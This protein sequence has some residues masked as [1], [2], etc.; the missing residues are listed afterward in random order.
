MLLHRERYS[1]RI[2][3][4]PV[5]WGDLLMYENCLV[6]SNWTWTFK[7]ISQVNGLDQSIDIEVAFCCNQHEMCLRWIYSASSWYH[8]GIFDPCPQ[9]PEW[10]G[11]FR[12]LPAG[13]LVESAGCLLGGRLGRAH[14]HQPWVCF[15]AGLRARILKVASE[16]A[17]LQD[18]STIIPCFSELDMAPKKAFVLYRDFP[19]ISPNHFKVVQCP[20][21]KLIQLR[22]RPCSSAVSWW[23]MSLTKHPQRWCWRWRVS[24][25][26]EQNGR[27]SNMMWMWAI[28][29]KTWKAWKHYQRYMSWYA[30]G[31]PWASMIW[32]SGYV[33]QHLEWNHPAC[34]YKRF[35]S[36]NE[37]LGF[38]HVRGWAVKYA[39]YQFAT[40]AFDFLNEARWWDYF[41]GRPAFC[42]V[43]QCEMS[44]PTGSDDS[45]ELSGWRL[46]E[47]RLE[48][49]RHECNGMT[50]SPPF[51]S[52][53]CLK[54]KQI[55]IICGHVL[56]WLES[57]TNHLRDLGLPHVYDAFTL[58]TKG[59]NIWWTHIWIQ[60]CNSLDNIGHVKRSETPICRWSLLRIALAFLSLATTSFG[61]WVIAACFKCEV[62]L[63]YWVL[64]W[65]ESAGG[66]GKIERY[67]TVSKVLRHLDLLTR[68]KLKQATF[69]QA[70][71]NLPSR[72]STFRKLRLCLP[73][74]P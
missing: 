43:S 20:L 70:S 72:F 71:A 23:S 38:G 27:Y 10:C 55:W 48:P 57:V 1:L 53:R 63:E 39:Q 21:V 41:G 40:A 7:D 13:V 14:K 64:E 22:W 47:G 51:S 50:T 35:R 6:I 12:R 28:I 18:R 24:C 68:L 73:C 74:H 36:R 8:S 3:E 65:W 44:L 19:W 61:R 16:M 26:L 5:G 49:R 46:V 32:H 58:I 31:N 9:S 11:F 60:N 59:E 15:C 56:V 54:R 67:Q 17:E 45:S 62:N 25:T 34:F 66:D 52:Q 4:G 30:W 37:Q 42:Q 69:F 33:W 2:L 29:R